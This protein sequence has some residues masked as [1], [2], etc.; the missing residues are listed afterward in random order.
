MGCTGGT[1]KEQVDQRMSAWS[2]PFSCS[3]AVGS[4]DV[5]SIPFVQYKLSRLTTP[6]PLPPGVPLIR[7]NNDTQAQRSSTRQGGAQM[8][9]ELSNRSTSQASVCCLPASIRTVETTTSALVV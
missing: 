7:Y 8:F 5:V 6:S 3:D 1:E 4:R 9:Q 2:C